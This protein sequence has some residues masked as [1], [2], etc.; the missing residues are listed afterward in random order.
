LLLRL[1]CEVTGPGRGARPPLDATVHALRGAAQGHDLI[2]T[3]GGVSVGEEDHVKPA[4]QASARSSC[5][6]SP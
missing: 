3:S 4:V 5:G 6:S 1:G 2:V